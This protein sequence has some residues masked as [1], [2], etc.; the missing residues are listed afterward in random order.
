MRPRADK[1]IRT[2]DAPSTPFRMAID[3]AAGRYSIEILCRC[4]NFQYFNGLLTI[5]TLFQSII[6]MA[7]DL[8]GMVATSD[9]IYEAF[10][11]LIHSS[12]SFDS[13]IKWIEKKNT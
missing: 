13:I 3:D 8:L 12:S 11:T 7:I 2:E 6:K 10:T 1:V 9:A 4:W 5:Q